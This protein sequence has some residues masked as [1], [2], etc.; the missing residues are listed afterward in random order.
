MLYA[1]MSFGVI[2]C[3]AAVAMAITAVRALASEM[4]FILY[5][6]KNVV[7]F[8]VLVLRESINLM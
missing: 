2:P 3:G 7:I 8:Y 6:V 5:S 4:T 1:V